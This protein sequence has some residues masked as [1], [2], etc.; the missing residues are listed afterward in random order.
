MPELRQIPR[1]QIG[2][3]A[4]LKLR[5]HDWENKCFVEDLNL[6]G[7]KVS[8][9][10]KLPEDSP[11]GVVLDIK[12]TLSLNVQVRVCW[13]VKKDGR[14]HYGLEFSQIK[15]LDKEEISQYIL[16]NCHEQIKENWWPKA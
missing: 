14:F 9:K 7:L 6:K 3:K 16:K 5:E 8:I 15:D 10:E 1:W 4:R 12:N 13:E 11:L 2:E